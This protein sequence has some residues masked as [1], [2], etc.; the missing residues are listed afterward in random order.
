[1][2]IGM[3]VWEG[4]GRREKE[5]EG[6]R[7]REE[8]GRGRGY[9]EI[10]LATNE[11]TSFIDDA[12]TRVDA[13]NQMLIGMEVREG[14]GREEGT[15]E[16]KTDLI[17]EKKIHWQDRVDDQSHGPNLSRLVKQGDGRTN[18]QNQN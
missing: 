17:L 2:L 13:R 4:G 11:F 5:G 16:F 8:E 15:K 6:G 7:R 12:A 10:E 1:M 9:Q 3:E 18:G 14:A